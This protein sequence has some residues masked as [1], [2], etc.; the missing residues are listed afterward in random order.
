MENRTKQIIIGIVITLLIGIVI[1]TTVILG[2]EKKEKRELQN[3]INE[4]KNAIELPQDGDMT[5]ENPG[6]AVQTEQ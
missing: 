2:K 5:G 3:E 4:I 1:V 6:Q